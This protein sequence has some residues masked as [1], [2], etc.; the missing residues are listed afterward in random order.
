MIFHN[1]GPKKENLFMQ[2]CTQ[3]QKAQDEFYSAKVPLSFQNAKQI[4][5]G[6]IK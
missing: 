3:S 5:N 2:I 1:S 4:S 6:T